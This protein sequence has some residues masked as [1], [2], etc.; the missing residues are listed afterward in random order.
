MEAKEIKMKW[1]NIHTN[2]LKNDT[3][4]FVGTIG[5]CHNVWINERNEYYTNG[6]AGWINVS[7]YVK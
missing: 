5:N 3:L 1:R 4:T 2:E 7:K 6:N